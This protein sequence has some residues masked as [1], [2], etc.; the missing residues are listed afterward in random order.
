MNFN[1]FDKKLIK[2]GLIMLSA[3]LLSLALVLGLQY[4]YTGELFGAFQ[5]HEHW[6]HHL[7]FPNFPIHTFNTHTTFSE[8]FSF[9]F[10]VLSGIELLIIF[11]NKIK[12]LKNRDLSIL[13]NEH[14]FSLSYI[15]CV[16]F[17]VLFIQGGTLTSLNRYV[18]CVAF[19]WSAFEYYRG[20]D[21]RK[22]LLSIMIV[23]LCLS[24]ALFKNGV[25]NSSLDYFRVFGFLILL[26]TPFFIHNLKAK[27]YLFIMSIIG[28][29]ILQIHFY[30]LMFRS[31]WVG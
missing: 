14:L 27:K 19:F 11:L 5:T 17:I 28:C 21:V 31:M 18:L 23:V 8:I 20:L 25:F 26:S 30:H 12:V 10:G 7:R 16:S 24:G 15:F 4:T 13:K 29:F 9:S 6:G 1:K 3:T 22:T 2:F